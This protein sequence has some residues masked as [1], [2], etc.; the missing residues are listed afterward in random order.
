MEKST[1][2]IDGPV[3]STK[4]GVAYIKTLPSPGVISSDVVC[5]NRYLRTDY[6]TVNCA[7]PLWDGE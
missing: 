4:I 6:E 5:A 7:S 1:L 3:A 2:D